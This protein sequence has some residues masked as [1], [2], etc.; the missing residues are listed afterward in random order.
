MIA[1]KTRLTKSELIDIQVFLESLMELPEGD[2]MLK[3]LQ[4]LCK[5]LQKMA[6]ETK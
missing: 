2:R 5:K 4:R 3:Q 1:K 6:G